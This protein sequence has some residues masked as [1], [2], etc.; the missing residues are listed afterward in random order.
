[1]RPVSQLSKAVKVV[2]IYFMSMLTACTPTVTPI[3]P[4]TPTFTAPTPT[5]TGIET[6]TPTTPPPTPTV[7]FPPT[8]VSTATPIL[9]PTL[10]TLV[11]NRENVCLVKATPLPPGAAAPILVLS[12]AN[13]IALVATGK[14]LPGVGTG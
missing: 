3:P 1:M 4:L 5:L 12:T 6:L 11:A 2:V 13:E 7:I 10:A 8:Q 14:D 9:M